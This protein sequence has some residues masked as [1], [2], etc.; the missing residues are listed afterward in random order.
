MHEKLAHLIT[1]D[2]DEMAGAL[3]DLSDKE[4]MEMIEM[5]DT[6]RGIIKMNLSRRELERELNSLMRKMGKL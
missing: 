3:D 6:V 4:L 1:C 5:L 2:M